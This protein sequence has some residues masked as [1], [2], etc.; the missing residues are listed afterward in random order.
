MFCYIIIKKYLF[1]FI[2]RNFF[3]LDNGVIKV[4]VDEIYEERFSF[5]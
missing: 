5:F 2:V 1:F 4:Y 3:D